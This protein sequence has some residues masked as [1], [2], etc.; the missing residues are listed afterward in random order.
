MA[1][2]VEEKDKIQNHETDMMIKAA[3]LYY[4]SGLTQGEIAKILGVS[5]QKTFRLIKKA[6]EMGLVEVRIRRPSEMHEELSFELQKK[7]SLEGAVVAKAYSSTLDSIIKA[8][9][10]SGADYFREQLQPYATIGVAYG[11]TLH[12]VI[13][14]FPKID[15]P[16]VRV[17]QMMGAYGGIRWQTLAIELIK[18]LTDKLGG[19]AVYLFAPAFAESSDIRDAFLRERSIQETLRIAENVDIALVGIGGIQREASLLIETGDL[20]K[21]EIEELARAGAVGGI[22]GNFF[23][24]EGEVIIA[25]LNSRRIAVRLGE[26]RKNSKKIIGIAGGEEKKKAIL[27]ALRGHWITHL[28]TDENTARWLLEYR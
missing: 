26:L 12:E 27:G 21:E 14:Y 9:A 28:V 5:R 3:E 19:E 24:E 22:C 6:R 13:Q 7:F 2:P 8:V 16:G 10:Q 4:I 25:N 23:N 15:V 1:L 20:K 11:R 18:A 17:V